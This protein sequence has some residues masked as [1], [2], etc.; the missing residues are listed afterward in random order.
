MPINVLYEI[1]VVKSRAFSEQI[2]RRA[3]KLMVMTRL[4]FVNNCLPALFWINIIL[5]CIKL[6]LASAGVVPI[7]VNNDM[8][9]IH[10]KAL[11]VRTAS[12]KD[13]SCKMIE[14]NSL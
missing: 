10:D 8:A 11:F 13:L 1:F 14:Q 12:I 9:N 6:L 3:R 5:F 7:E 4:R 2:L